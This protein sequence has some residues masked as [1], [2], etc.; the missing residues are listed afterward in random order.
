MG[1]PSSFAALSNKVSQSVSVLHLKTRD[2]EHLATATHSLKGVPA[3]THAETR[4]DQLG[5]YD[6]VPGRRIENGLMVQIV[7]APK[8]DA[9]RILPAR[10]ITPTMELPPWLLHEPIMAEFMN[11]QP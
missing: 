6:S 11:N 4:C 3:K 8:T 9:I 1:C 5:E 10:F 2:R 7:L